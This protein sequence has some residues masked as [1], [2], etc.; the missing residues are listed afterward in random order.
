MAL[1]PSIYLNDRVGIAVHEW[2][3]SEHAGQRLSTHRAVTAFRCNS[4]TGGQPSGGRQLPPELGKCPQWQAR[5]RI[6]YEDRLATAPPDLANSA[7]HRLRLLKEA[8]SEATLSLRRE[9]P[10]QVQNEDVE[11]RLDWIMRGLTA[12]RR[13]DRHVLQRAAVAV[14]VSS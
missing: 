11:E 3:K 6:F 13:G 5:T 14:P 9:P 10:R 12:H 2:V 7:F 8:M 1:H 4:D